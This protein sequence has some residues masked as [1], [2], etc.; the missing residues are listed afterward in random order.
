MKRSEIEGHGSKEHK[1]D[2]AERNRGVWLK[3]AQGQ[4]KQ[5]GIIF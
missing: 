4:M 5:N 2:E 1:P 3:R